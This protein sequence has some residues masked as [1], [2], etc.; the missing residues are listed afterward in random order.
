MS[1]HKTIV[2]G[3]IHDENNIILVKQAYDYRLWTLPGGKVD[4]GESLVQAASCEVHEETGLIAEPVGLYGVRDK[5]TQTVFVFDMKITGGKMV[6]RMPGEINAVQWFR[7]GSFEA[8]MERSNN[9]LP[10]S[11]SDS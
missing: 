3:L 10:T 6:E 4:K 1:E 11:W 7:R 9:F 5:P 8:A 2:V